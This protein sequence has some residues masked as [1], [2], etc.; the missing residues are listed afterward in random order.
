MGVESFTVHLTRPSSKYFYPGQT[1]QGEVVI[2]NRKNT[3]FYGKHN[4]ALSLVYN[5]GLII[6]FCDRFVPKSQ[7]ER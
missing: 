3:I 2:A 4:S 7:G 5:I 6:S 1:V